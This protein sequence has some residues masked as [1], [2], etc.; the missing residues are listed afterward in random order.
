MRHKYTIE[1]LK[2]AVQESKSIANVLRLL[3]IRPVGGNYKTIKDLIN[4]HQID[5]SHFTGQGWNVGLQFRPQK[6]FTDKEVFV[7]NSTYKSSVKLKKRYI[8]ITNK[9]NCEICGVK[10]W[11]GKPLSFEI[12]HKNGINTDNRLENLMLLCPNCH[13][14]TDHYRGKQT[15]SALSEMKAKEYQTFKEAI[16]NEID[17]ENNSLNNIIKSNCKKDIIK[18]VLE[19]KYCLYCGKELLGKSR[20]NKYCSVE[21]YQKDNSKNRPSVFELIEA[22]KQYKSYVQVGKHYGVSDNAVRKWVF[23]YHIENIIK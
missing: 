5:I 14:Q 6:C 3:G 10:E 9:N 19:S 4:R 2:T 16:T 15:S 17:S 20:K 11:N 8:K 21:C 23:L 7:E 18:K 1:E 12:H 13:S 22:F